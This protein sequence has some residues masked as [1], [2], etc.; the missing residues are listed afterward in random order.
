MNTTLNHILTY[1]GNK[2]MN[3]CSYSY[4][5]GFNGEEMD[6]EVFRSKGTNYDL[7]ARTYDPRIGRMRSVDPWTDKYPWQSTYVYHRNSPIFTVDWKGFGDEDK[8]I[9]KARAAAAAAKA[10]AN[11]SGTS[12]TSSTDL[13]N[14]AV[15]S[16]VIY[17]SYELLQSQNAR[18]QYLK[19]AD[20]LAPGDG[21]ARTNLKADIRAKT[22]PVTL[23]IIEKN[24]P[25]LESRTGSTSS[26]NK[27][28]PKAN[29]TAKTMG[30]I[31]KPLLVLAVANSVNNI[32]NAENK[33]EATAIEGGSWAGALS[34]GYIAGSAA[35]PAG[36]WAAAGASFIGSIIG[37]YIGEEAVTELFT[38]NE[39]PA[40]D[41]KSSIAEDIEYGDL[42]PQEMVRKH[43]CFVKGTKILMSDSSKKNIEDIKEGDL[44]LNVDIE[45][46]TIQVD[47]VLL[48][49]TELK[50]YRK[51]VAVFNNGTTNEFSPAHPYFVLNKGWAVYDLDE[52]KTELEFNV[53]KL[54]VG[55]SVYYYD[56]GIL[57][58]T[59]I[60]SI[61]DTKDYIEMYNI[62]N[63]KNNHTFFANGILVHNKYIDPIIRNN[64]KDIEKD[65]SQ[66]A[67]QQGKN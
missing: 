32:A 9:L 26:A 18:N 24:R 42:D 11:S 38:P 25:S 13:A 36:P 45:S 53:V 61:T 46:K 35:A 48:V 65:N 27:T 21:V 2:L 34:G 41:R 6:D 58:S 23:S 16:A 20:K 63:V 8:L 12:S 54:E 1:N 64:D 33:V 43:S 19:A 3:N 60:I 22:P 50:K 47:T 67:K 62:E 37:G 30:A 44:I 51:I 31:G 66:N 39:N 10:K 56:K 14:R 17:T 55:D 52:A 29:S 15:S 59:T 7:G 49:P 4:R 57:K 5:Y 28:N 40:M